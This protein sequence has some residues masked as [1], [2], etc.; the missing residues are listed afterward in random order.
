MGPFAE[1]EPETAA[2]ECRPL[3]VAT[4]RLLSGNGKATGTLLTGFVADQAAVL[5][6]FLTMAGAFAS[7]KLDKARARS[8]LASDGG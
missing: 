5:R 4:E 3:K 7:R 1:H 6:A 8:A 2:D